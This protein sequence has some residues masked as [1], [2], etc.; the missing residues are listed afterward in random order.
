MKDLTQ[1]LMVTTAPLIVLA[2]GATPMLIFAHFWDKHA[3]KNFDVANAA[4]WDDEKTKAFYKHLNYN[5]YLRIAYTITLA[6][7]AVI[8]LSYGVIKSNH[9]EDVFIY[10]QNK[11][12]ITF[13]S[14]NLYFRTDTFT[15]N[16][17]TKTTYD[18]KNGN[19]IYTVYKHDL[20]KLPRNKQ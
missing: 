9:P 2:I 1:S 12:T 16:R 20:A 11:D 15:I 18:L 7:S 6:I 17:E 3:T 14:H 13:I 8:G 10:N 4:S 19:N 5:Y